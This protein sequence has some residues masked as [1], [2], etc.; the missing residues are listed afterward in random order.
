MTFVGSLQ[1]HPAGPSTQKSTNA[2]DKE[3]REKK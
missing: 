3:I 2:R 1:E